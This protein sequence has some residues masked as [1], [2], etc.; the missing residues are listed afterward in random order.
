MNLHMNLFALFLLVASASASKVG[1]RSLKSNKQG[2]KTAKSTKVP[3]GAVKDFRGLQRAINDGDG[4]IKLFSGTIVFTEGM[5]L[6]NSL[7]FT[8]PNGGCILDAKSNIRFFNITKEAT[9]SFDG[10]TFQ[11]GFGKS[12]TLGGA[13]YNAGA[14]SITGSKFIGNKGVESGG[15]IFNQLGSL[16]ITRSEFQENTSAAYGGAI[17]SINGPMNITESKFTDNTSGAVG[18]AIWNLQEKAVI[19]GCEFQGNTAKSGAADIYG[20][21]G[22]VECDD[23]N[24]FSTPEDGSDVTEPADIFA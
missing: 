17:F 12:S 5:D 22:E 19:T 23:N 9:I 10:I 14:L 7:T 13:I 8:C 20:A 2:P 16:S 15:A 6:T 24:T 18:G 1:L 11:N 3:K 4:D 21:D